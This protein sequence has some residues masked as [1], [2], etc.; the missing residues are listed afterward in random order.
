MA[1]CGLALQLVTQLSGPD[2]RRSAAA[3]REFAETAIAAVASS[4]TV[5]SNPSQMTFQRPDQLLASPLSPASAP[6]T[7]AHISNCVTTPPARL[8]PLRLAQNPG[9]EPRTRL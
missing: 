1:C 6:V 4:R 5:P 2:P 7:P 8:G 9:G 3:E